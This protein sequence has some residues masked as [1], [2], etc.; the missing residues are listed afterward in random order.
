MEAEHQA[1]LNGSDR[2]K[3]YQVCPHCRRVINLESACNH[4]TCKCKGEFCYICG[5]AEN[6]T[7]ATGHWG[8]GRGQCFQF[9][10]QAR[11]AAANARRAAEAA[12]NARAAGNLDQPPVELDE[13][14]RALQNYAGRGVLFG[15]EIM[16]Q[17]ANTPV[18]LADQ[19]WFPQP[20]RERAL[21]WRELARRANAPVVQGVQNSVQALGVDLEER[22]QVPED[23]IAR[24][25]VQDQPGEVEGAGLQEGGEEEVAAPDVA[26]DP[27]G[28]EDLDNEEDPHQ[29]AAAALGLYAQYYING[30]GQR[31][32][33][34]QPPMPPDD[35]RQEREDDF[36]NEG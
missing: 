11:E 14:P 30:H 36:F 29:H 26:A 28:D 3:N 12:A 4:I 18:A 15:W 7:T 1:L 2:G 27:E 33:G 5:K 35:D 25:G 22:L 8:T 21:G 16:A 34:Q 24:L 13:G 17:R 19:I 20:E 32:Y 6:D 10:W 23:R 9:P 31:I